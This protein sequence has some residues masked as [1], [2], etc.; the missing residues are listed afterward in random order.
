MNS[1]NKLILV[2]HEAANPDRAETKSGT[3]FVSFPVATHRNSTSDGVKSDGVKK[4]VTDYH[5]V[6]AWGKLGEDCLT[7]LSQGQGVYVEGSIR[8]RAYA[9]RTANADSSQRFALTK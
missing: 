2:G 4:E 6:I 5:R 1:V 3:V 7:H 9:R 8:N